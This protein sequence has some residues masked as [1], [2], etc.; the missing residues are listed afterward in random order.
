MTAQPETNDYRAA[1]EGTDAE[2]SRLTWLS[3]MIADYADNR[4]HTDDVAEL[5]A[6]GECRALLDGLR[7]AQAKAGGRA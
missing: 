2:M 3:A 5:T 6:I 1:C 4:P 7:A